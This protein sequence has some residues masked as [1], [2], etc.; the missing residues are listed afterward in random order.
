MRHLILDGSIGM[1]AIHELLARELSFPAYYG[2]NLD[3]LYDCLTEVQEDVEIEVINMEYLGRKGHAL[4]QT[5]L[6]ASLSN[7]HITA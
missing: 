5:I 3:A 6:D 4:Q 2:K 7:P 1:D